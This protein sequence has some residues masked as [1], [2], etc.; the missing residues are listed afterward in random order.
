M[1]RPVA[2]PCRPF[3]SLPGVIYLIALVTYVVGAGILWF[4]PFPGLSGWTLVTAYI[5]HYL[6]TGTVVWLCA[7]AKLVRAAR[8]RNY[9]WLLCGQLP[10][11][12]WFSGIWQIAIN[13]G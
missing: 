5:V 12:I 1:C 8:D 13:R 10:A 6:I 4:V 2:D 11:C 7:F 9:L 3:H